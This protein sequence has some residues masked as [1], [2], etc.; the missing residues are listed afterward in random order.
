VQQAASGTSEASVNVAGASHA[1]AR[2]GRKRHGGVRRAHQHATS[3]CV[4]TF[5]ADLRDAG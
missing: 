5:L 2:A 4:D 3:K 1:A